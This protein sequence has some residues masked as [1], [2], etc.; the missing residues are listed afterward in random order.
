MQLT[1]MS[2]QNLAA[3]SESDRQLLSNVVAL[4]EETYRP[5]LQQ[6][7]EVLSFD[8]FFGAKS[9]VVLHEADFPIGF[10]LLNSRSLGL[11][12]VEKCSYF[13]ALPQHILLEIQSTNESLFSI[14]W[15]TVHPQHRAKFRK[16]Q[17]ADLIMGIGF[18]VFHLSQHSMAIGFSRT[19]VGADRIAMNFGGR[20]FAEIQLHG[21]PCRVMLGRR[22]WIGSHR[23]SIVERA[24]ENLWNSRRIVAP[25]LL[26]S[27]SVSV[28]NQ[29]EG[30]K[31]AA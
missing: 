13:R 3:L 4:W 20:G 18:R 1:Y 22:E 27:G 7:G 25:S 30:L 31:N 29:L 28:P 14:E 9:I 19:D 8:D 5:I 16:V 17:I 12:G 2:L 15:V 23:F 11:K 24:I 21:I 26:D 6:A 10:C